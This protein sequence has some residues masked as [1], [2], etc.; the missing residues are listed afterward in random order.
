MGHNLPCVSPCLNLEFADDRK[1]RGVSG[2]CAA[3]QRDI[4]GLEM[5]PTSWAQQREVRN[6]IYGE[7]QYQTQ[8]LERKQLCRKGPGRPGAH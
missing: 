4:R 5:G 8:G 3:I 1:L 2:G 7:E 6:P